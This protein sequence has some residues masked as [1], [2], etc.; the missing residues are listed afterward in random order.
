V[1]L[2]AESRNPSTSKFK[3]DN[4]NIIDNINDWFRGNSLLLNF[5]RAYFLQFRPKNSCE[6]NIKISRDNNLIKETKNTKFLGLDVAS[7]LSWNNHIDQ[8]MIKLSRACYAIRY[9]KHLMSHDT[10]RAI[11]FSYFNSI[12]LL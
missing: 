8:M 12:L 3:E 4:N 9:L 6:I 11:Y 10:P 7:S 1:H 2:C 5:D